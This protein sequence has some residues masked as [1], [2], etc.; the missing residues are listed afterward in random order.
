MG[1]QHVDSRAL[2]VGRIIVEWTEPNLSRLDMALANL[3][4]WSRRH[5]TVGSASQEWEQI[6]KRPWREI[7]TI[8]HDQSPGGGQRLRESDSFVGIV[9]DEERIATMK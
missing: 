8:L 5:G 9:T 7:Q 4:R 1:D 6:L 2:D 3:K